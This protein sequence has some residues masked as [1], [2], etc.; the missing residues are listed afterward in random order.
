MLILGS[1][2]TQKEYIYIQSDNVVLNVREETRKHG[3]L[4]PLLSFTFIHSQLRYTYDTCDNCMRT[5]INAP[6]ISYPCDINR[7]T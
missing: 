5:S 6:R 1:T 7:N 3:N 2:T 4:S